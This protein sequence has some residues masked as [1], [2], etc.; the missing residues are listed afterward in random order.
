MHW[1][2]RKSETDLD[3][4]VAYHL[5]T[6]ADSYERQGMTRDEALRQ[7]RREFGGVEKIKDECRDESRWNWFLQA[8][9]DIRFG[10]RMMRKTP[11]TTAAAVLS[12]ALGIGAT[13]A[14]LSLADAVL[15]RSLALPAPEQL[16]EVLW[17][18]KARP[19]GIYRSSSGS[20]YPENGGV[21]ADHF[22]RQSWQ[23]MRASVAGKAD[24]AAHYSSRLVSASY[25]GT[26]V[27]ARLRGV[28][29]NFFQ[30]LQVQPFEGRLIQESDD[31]NG[32]VP[33]VVVTHRFWLRHLGGVPQAA[34][35]QTVR[36]NNVAYAIAGVLPPSFT[37]IVPGDDSE[38]YT[39]IQQSSEVLAADTW[40][41]KEQDNPT[42]WWLQLMAR[43]SPGVSETE[44]KTILDTS[45]AG[46]WAGAPKRPEMTPHIRLSEASR[47]LGAMRRRFGDPVWILLGLVSLVL[48]VACANIANLLLARAVE[49]EK[50]VALRISLGCGERRLVRQF[51]TESLLLAACGGILSVAVALLLGRLILTVL[52]TG[53]D[54]KALSLDPNP[55]TLLGTAAVAL[56]TAILFG[57]YPAFRTARVNISPA[58][59]EGSGSGG[60]MSRSR[61]APAKAL[62][63]VQVALGVLL[64]TTAIV[65]TSHLNELANRDTGFE[66]GNAILFDIRPGEIGYRAER[67][68]QFYFTI[69]DRLGGLAGVEAVGLSQT[70]PML[71]GGYWDDAKLPG[72]TKT[73]GVAVHHGNPRFLTALGLPLVAGR[74]VTPQEVRTR[75]KVAVVSEDLAEALGVPAATGHTIAVSENQYE[76]IGVAKRAQYSQMTQKTPILYLPFDYETNAASVIVRTALPPQAALGAIRAAVKDLDANL[77]LVD[78]YTLEQQIS[79]TLQRERMFA[80]LCGSFGVLALVLCV[81]GLYGLMSHTTARRT[82]EI[83]IRIALG[84]S[85]GNVLGQV[86]REG[87]SLAGAGLVFGVPIA[88]FGVRL[89][90]SQKLLPKGE[91]PYWTLAAAIGVLAVS[92]FAAV[93][94]PAWRASTV[95]PMQALRRG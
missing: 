69:E 52:P 72:Q 33:V 44:V 79:R 78:V 83:G 91:L 9:Q 10:W 84:A 49:R 36:I 21:V 59:K 88:Y 80:W 67:L 56:F 19:Q 60:T 25:A 46:S 38:L 30:M 64:V 4:E 63:L 53:F 29:G 76:I 68:R 26:V 86:L 47:G 93:L 81:V 58:L 17:E 27:V 65:F 95:D 11:T 1:P 77:P 89:A 54:G 35:N 94:A 7:A 31:T 39:G 43:R 70:R 85:R 48:F 18:A 92:A 74:T 40:V 73:I 32:A 51:F 71:G 6:L 16:M 22:S 3:R 13:T 2:W 28:S 12:L 15:W 37:G 61:W 24:V 57:L 20:M 45:F 75:A 41:H 90:E 50:E 8:S 55:R 87:L 23:A 34:L 14:I 82:S 66:R 5:E 62:V 42:T